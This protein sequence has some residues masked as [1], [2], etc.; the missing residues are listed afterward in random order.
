MI[1]LLLIL[2]AVC[3]VLFTIYAARGTSPNIQEPHQ[4]QGLTTSIDI[5]AFRN[6]VSR[7]E[8]D[9]L[10][11]NLPPAEFRRIQRARLLAALAYVRTAAHN[12]AILLRL[13][14]TGRRSSDPLVATSAAELAESALQVR[15]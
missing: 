12:A 2:G 4:L 11:R 9:Y 5:D 10:R 3:A 8:E 13:A 6:L 15:L 1:S 14:E 7:A